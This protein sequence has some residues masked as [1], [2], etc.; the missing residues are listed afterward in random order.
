MVIRL[1][2]CLKV[3]YA[4]ALKVIQGSFTVFWGLGCFFIFNVVTL[5]GEHHSG[6]QR[7]ELYQFSIYLLVPEHKH[8]KPLFLKKERLHQYYYIFAYVSVKQKHMQMLNANKYFNKPYLNS[9]SIENVNTNI[10]YLP[11]SEELFKS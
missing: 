3:Y 10:S 5:I 6:F 8:Y 2:K 7:C 4:K 11:Y 1:R 9:F